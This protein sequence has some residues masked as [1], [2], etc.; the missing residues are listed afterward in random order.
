MP[1]LLFT[2]SPLSPLPSP[3]ALAGADQKK[4]L[5]AILRRPGPA[6]RRGGKRTSALSAVLLRLELRS[7]MGTTAP[8]NLDTHDDARNPTPCTLTAEHASQDRAPVPQAAAQVRFRVFHTRPAHPHQCR[9]LAPGSRAA[10]AHAPDAHRLD[11][12]GA[13]RPMTK[14]STMT[15]RPTAQL[16]SK[17]PAAPPR[18]QWRLERRR[19]MATSS[20]C[21]PLPLRTSSGPPTCSAALASASTA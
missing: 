1:G 18:R 3:W 4:N 14:R 16:W 8:T 15:L 19:L 20:L 9:A 6:A 17:L 10:P 5:P 12:S 2:D 13:R 11:S 21:P 7:A